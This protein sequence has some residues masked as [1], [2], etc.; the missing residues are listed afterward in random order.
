MVGETFGNYEVV[1]TLGKGG[2]GV[3]YLAQHHTIARRA[4]IKVLAP[5]LSKDRDVVKRFFLEA[6]ATSLIRH[7][8]IVEVFDY[9]VEASGRAYIVMEYLEG[10]TLAACLER[11]GALSWQTACAIAQR[12]A[13]ALGAAH[14]HGIVHRDLKPGN[15]FVSLVAASSYATERRIKVLDFGLAKLLSED[16]GNEPITRAGMLLGTPMYI[17]PEQCT[18]AEQI[19]RS[20]DV[21]ALGC[22][23][24]EMLCGVPPFEREGIRAILAAHMFEPAPRTSQRAPGVPAWLDNLV[25][26]MLA[27]KPEERPASM[28][29]VAETLATAGHEDAGL[30]WLM[31]GSATAMLPAT[32]L[33]PPPP[34]PKFPWRDLRLPRVRLPEIRLPQVRWPHLSQVARHLE[35][36]PR[37]SRVARNLRLSVIDRRVRRVGGV[38]IGLVAL[39]IVGALALARG[40]HPH[41]PAAST[42]ATSA[43]GVA[44][45]AP[46]KVSDSGLLTA[47]TP[48]PVAEPLAT[49]P[50]AAV[51]V[52]GSPASI[53]AGP[54]EIPAPAK[55]RIGEAR[56]HRR[57]EPSRAR[58]PVEAD[59][60]TD[61]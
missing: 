54:A 37:L 13:S 5:E 14:G 8:G 43:R 57:P 41:T 11:T 3:V 28:A 51:V 26:R 50:T 47:V 46:T 53:E 6:L 56:A 38:A 59:G 15:V 55:R 21:Y 30:T 19:T 36:L 7:P 27:K 22:I 60:I 33:P 42:V 20:A 24:Y 18:G 34:P 4:A 52:P 23:L 32:V 49:P 61:L 58:A 16:P 9:D 31:P 1:A 35:R 10:E 29:E 12:I 40:G 25:A 17:S 39:V 44:A 2:V 45:P 48:A